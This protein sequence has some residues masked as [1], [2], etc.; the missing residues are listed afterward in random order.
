[1]INLSVPDCWHHMPYESLFFPKL[2]FIDT[3]W[4]ELY[5]TLNKVQDWKKK[6]RQKRVWMQDDSFALEN[7]TL[8]TKLYDRLYK[9]TDA[10]ITIFVIL[11]VYH[12]SLLQGDSNPLYVSGHGLD[13]SQVSLTKKNTNKQSFEKNT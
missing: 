3:E 13:S 8:L 7:V 11:Y 1:M 10:F 9:N 5:S 12:S 6:E 4:D 2:F